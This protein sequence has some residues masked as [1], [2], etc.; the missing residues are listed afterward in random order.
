MGE[1]LC[2]TNQ[3]SATSLYTSR[4]HYRQYPHLS[5]LHWSLY[6]Y[7]LWQS[8]AILPWY[9]LFR[10]W[11][12]LYV[13]FWFYSK[14]RYR[15]KSWAFALILDFSLPYHLSFSLD[16]IWSYRYRYTRIFPLFRQCCPL[17][18]WWTELEIKIKLLRMGSYRDLPKSNLVI[19]WRYVFRL[20]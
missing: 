14:N 18:C 6:A 16:L 8:R 2:L 9:G 17:F 12:C 3:Q 19:I 1:I 11:Y 20:L 10:M 7:R 13:T 5:G 4:E 15:S